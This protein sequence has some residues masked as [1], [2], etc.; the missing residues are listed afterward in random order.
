MSCPPVIMGDRNEK[1][2][3]VKP[4]TLSKSRF[5]LAL[6]CPTKVFYSLDKR[7]VDARKDDE[8]LEA[9]AD[10]G[11]Q[12]GALTKAMY[13]A[14]DPAAV[15][16]T[17]TG[18]DAQ[19]RETAAMLERENVT[20]FEGTIR[21][22]NLLVR[23]DVLKKRGNVVE[24]IE[25]KAKS[26]DRSEDS[27][28]GKTAKSNPLAPEWEPYVYDIAFQERVL[29]QCYPGLEVRPRLL[30]INKTAV[31]SLAGLGLKF[32]ITGTERSRS[33]DPT[34]DFRVAD[35]AQPLLVA[36]DATAAIK[37]AQTQVRK[38][39]G[40]PDI[41]FDSLV[42]AAAG[43][44]ARGER[45][46]PY[47]GQPCKSCEFYCVPEERSEVTRSGWAECMETVLKAPIKDPARA[48][49]CSGFMAGQGPTSSSRRSESGCAISRKMTSRSKSR[50]KRSQAPR[51]TDC[52]GTR[53]CGRT[54]NR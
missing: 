26:W 38:K 27:L 47:V 5:K 51:V 45:L 35:L 9:L 29:K 12:V 11:F 32:P 48:F 3:P 52:S 30:L 13:L 24:L 2:R 34:E 54:T 20:I 17:V 42:D 49:R 10:G 31:N 18:D 6:E 25:V 1:G 43:A 15:E 53:S 50:P 14:E 4:K 41:V 22:G 46:G 28:T 23:V 44:I 16:V 33:A 37:V 8:F 39:K 40:R 7:Y 36:V 19:V 21:H